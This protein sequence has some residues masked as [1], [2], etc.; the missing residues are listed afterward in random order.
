[1]DHSTSNEFDALSFVDEES[2]L[3]DEVSDDADLA[4]SSDEENMRYEQVIRELT[5]F[6]ETYEHSKD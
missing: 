5:R 6:E 1:M 3:A 2:R 4:E